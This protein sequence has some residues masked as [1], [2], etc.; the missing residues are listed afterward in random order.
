M[1][2]ESVNKHVVQG[3]PLNTAYVDF[4]KLLIRSLAKD[5]YGNSALLG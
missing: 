3:P 1:F 5:P 4:H 2:F